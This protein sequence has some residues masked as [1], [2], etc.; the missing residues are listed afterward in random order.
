MTDIMYCVIGC[1][2]IGGSRPSCRDLHERPPPNTTGR[3]KNFASRHRAGRMTPM[4]SVLSVNVGLPKLVDFQTTSLPQT[5][6]EKLP[7]DGPVRITTYGVEGNACADTVN[8]G[9]E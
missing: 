4:G 7:V 1:S 6:I 5:G 2:L 8:H 3:P 9:D